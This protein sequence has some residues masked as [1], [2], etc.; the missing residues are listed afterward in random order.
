MVPAGSEPGP[1]S[2]LQVAVLEQGKKEGEAS[3]SPVDISEFVEK[4]LA[5]GLPRETVARAMKAGIEVAGGH[6]SDLGMIALGNVTAIR[7]VVAPL[8]RPAEAIIAIED[9][10][11]FAIG[12]PDH[13]W[14]VS[15]TYIQEKFTRRGR[16]VPCDA[17]ALTLIL[18]VV[19]RRIALVSGGCECP[20]HKEL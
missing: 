4:A 9:W 3:V 14:P 16:E 18:G 10:S 2:T 6:L 20:L 12:H 19:L 13:D 11:T 1:V 5:G 15:Y 17:V 7:M 8:Q